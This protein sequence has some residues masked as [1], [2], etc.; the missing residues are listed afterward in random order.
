MAFPGTYNFNYYR[1][2][3]YSFVITPKDASGNTFALDA[4]GSALF[5]IANKRGTGATQYGA[6]SGITASINTTDDT[7]TCTISAT[8]GRNLASGTTYV[9][10]VEITSGSIK[11]TI[12]TGTITPTDDITGAV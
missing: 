5:T 6:A 7:V 8:G 10:D 3:T 9:Y 1:G 2:D 4:F 11:Y 12:L